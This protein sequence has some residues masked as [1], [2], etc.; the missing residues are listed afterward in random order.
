M[1]VKTLS[2]MPGHMPAATT[3]DIYTHITDDMQHAA[4]RKIDCG[5][6]KAEIQDEPAPQP[7]AST[8]FVFRPSPK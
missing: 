4:A 3:L 2:A 8:I 1:D 7:N 5:I 6:G